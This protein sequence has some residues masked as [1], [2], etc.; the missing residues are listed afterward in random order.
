MFGTNAKIICTIVAFAASSALAEKTKMTAADVL[1]RIH[2][3]NQEEITAAQ[4]AFQKASSPK[5]KEYAQKLEEDHK[6][7]DAMVME[8]AQKEKIDLTAAPAPKTAGETGKM[9]KHAAVDTKLKAMGSGPNFDRAYI[10]AMEQGH[11]DVIQ[12]LESADTSDAKVKALVAEL[13]PKLKHHEHM[14]SQLQ[15]QVKKE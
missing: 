3:A 11:K 7:A 6:K 10:D 12:T 9:A 14:A 5:V 15:E 2:S 1:S 8:L 4:L 13:L